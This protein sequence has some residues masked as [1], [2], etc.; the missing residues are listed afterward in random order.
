MFFISLWGGVG[1]GAVCILCAV[2]MKLVSRDKLL[3]LYSNFD[4][5]VFIYGYNDSFD[6]VTSKKKN[7]F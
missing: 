5:Y 3:N 7:V 6:Y 1:N 4:R 2:P